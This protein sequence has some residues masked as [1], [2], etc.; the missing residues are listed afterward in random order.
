MKQNLKRDKEEFL[1]T[2]YSLAY[3][4]L[5]KTGMFFLSNSTVNKK[6]QIVEF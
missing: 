5:L 1:E 4:T 6:S 2:V 3:Y